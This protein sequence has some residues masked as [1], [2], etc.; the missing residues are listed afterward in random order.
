MEELMRTLREATVQFGPNLLA[1]IATLILGWLVSK[2]LR[3]G[4]LRTLLASRVD[5]TL[6]LFTVNLT[7][8]ALMALVVITALHQFGFPSISFAAVV[9]AAG[10]AVGLGLK[11]MLSN[12]AAGALLIGLRPFN[13]GDRIEAAGVSGV[14]ASI[15]VF[16]TCIET[17]GK[18]II[19]PN[20][21]MTGG[22]ITVHQAGN[23]R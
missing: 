10:L 23:G 14:V 21:S 19:I 13:V 20:G 6:A 8:I 3:A 17:E 11:G 16:T 1:G 2:I 5:R 22:N 12:L 9:G 18:R 15:H 4:L 7:Y